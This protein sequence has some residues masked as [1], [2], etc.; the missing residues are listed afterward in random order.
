MLPSVAR[1]AARAA[2]SEQGGGLGLVSLPPERSASH[3]VD[4]E[5]GATPV[6]WSRTWAGFPPGQFSG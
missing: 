4:C 3:G 2:A 5:G 6:T 1:D